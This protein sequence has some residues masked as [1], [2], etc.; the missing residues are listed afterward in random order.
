[1]FLHLHEIYDNLNG[2][3]KVNII[4]R[5]IGTKKRELEISNIVNHPLFQ[6]LNHIRQLGF[7]YQTFPSATHTRFSHSLGVYYLASNISNMFKEKKILNG[8]QIKPHI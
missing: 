4:L 3:I 6:R 7:A 2:F 5:G 1:M 8:H